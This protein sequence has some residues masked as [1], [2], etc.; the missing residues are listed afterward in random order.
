MH[1]TL[2]ILRIILRGHQTQTAAFLS[3]GW[4]KCLKIRN[5]Y[6]FRLQTTSIF[7]RISQ[8]SRQRHS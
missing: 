8:C 3:A 5:Q 7:N 1:L 6:C 4:L 2:L